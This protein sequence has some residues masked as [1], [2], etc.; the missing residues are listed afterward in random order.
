MVL[1]N[2][3]F[4]ST[5]ES[6]TANNIVLAV[7]RHVTNPESRQYLLRQAYEEAIHT[8]TFIYCCDSLGLDPDDIYT[9]YETIPSIKEKD[10]FVVSL[11]KSIFD[12]NFNIET[13]ENI[14]MLVRDLIGYYVIMEGI[15]FYAGFAMMLG[16]KRQNKLV[17]IGEQFEYIMRDE[18]VHLAFGCDLINTIK[19][20]HQEIWT[21]SFQNEIK[22]LIQTAVHFEIKYAKDACPNGLVGIKTDQFA[23]YIEYIADRRLQR[24]GLS[25]HYNQDNPFPWMSQ[26]TDINKEKNFFETRVTE[27]QSA[28]ALEWD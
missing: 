12:P 2:L 23:R 8:D 15:F 11:T 1:W 14:Q 24:L 27:Y 19:S 13:T 26:S 16:M 3:G 5:A 4:F 7:Y 21:D 6:L 22:A 18:S 28:G 10:D 25:P 17:G 9:M 20:E